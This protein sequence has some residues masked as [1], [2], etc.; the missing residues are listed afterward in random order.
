MF[1]E[2]F[3]NQVNIHNV[4]R[5]VLVT[6]VEYLQVCMDVHQGH[7]DIY[8][9]I[10]TTLAAVCQSYKIEQQTPQQISQIK[11]RNIWMAIE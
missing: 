10:Q 5:S 7:P 9:E 2:M 4:D 3:T 1:A 11:Q 8:L 6:F